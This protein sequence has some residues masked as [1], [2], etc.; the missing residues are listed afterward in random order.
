[1]GLKLHLVSS[2]TSFP[3]TKVQ[4]WGQNIERSGKSKIFHFWNEKMDRWIHRYIDSFT[5]LCWRY[6][7]WNWAGNFSLAIFW[8]GGRGTG[9]P[10]GWWE[11][12]LFHWVCSKCWYCA[13]VMTT[14]PIHDRMMPL[15]TL[16]FTFEKC[17]VKTQGHPRTRFLLKV[18]SCWNFL[19]DEIMQ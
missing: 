8:M 7:C 14:P 9:I 16:S 5:I 3:C 4:I 15:S 13:S 6:L 12:T 2:L 19:A 18:K 17:T 10:E 11:C 1:M